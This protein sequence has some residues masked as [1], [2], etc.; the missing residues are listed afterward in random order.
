[1]GRKRKIAP[2]P[3]AEELR[4]RLQELRPEIVHFF[5]CP[6]D[7]LRAEVVAGLVQPGVRVV[8]DFN[9]K[10]GLFQLDQGE[11]V[12]EADLPQRLLGG[13]GPYS[14]VLDYTRWDPVLGW[15]ENTM[16]HLFR[17]LSWSAYGGYWP[18]NLRI[19]AV[20][21]RLPW[22]I[23]NIEQ[24]TDGVAVVVRDPEM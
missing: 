5:A 16:W 15:D 10:T 7:A 23:Q 18:R 2:P 6:F 22:Y 9:A 20:G 13:R 8:V 12:K 1:M 3:S 17:F 24:Q 19:L 11:P 21:R 4:T 14:L